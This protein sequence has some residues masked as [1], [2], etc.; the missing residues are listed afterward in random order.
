MFPFREYNA[1]IFS[2]T[3]LWL[4]LGSLIL[5]LPLINMGKVVQR[6][7]KQQGASVW[8]YYVNSVSTSCDLSS[9][10]E[11]RSLELNFSYFVPP[12]GSFPIWGTHARYFRQNI[13]KGCY[14]SV[15]A[16]IQISGALLEL[17]SK[18]LRTALF[19]DAGWEHWWE[20][21]E[22]AENPGSFLLSSGDLG[23]FKPRSPEVAPREPAFPKLP[24]LFDEPLIPYVKIFNL[25]IRQNGFL[26]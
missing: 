25:Q 6:L 5:L 14:A 13:R 7:K 23:W 8:I 20:L 16:T 4:Q 10:P 18:P 26:M 12:G 21:P 1:R 24:Q 11:K 15:V 19:G 22:D 17:S 3:G 2:F 9:V